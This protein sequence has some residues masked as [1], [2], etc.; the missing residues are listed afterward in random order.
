M[1][2]SCMISSGLHPPAPR[3]AMEYLR[4]WIRCLKIS[5][6]LRRKLEPRGLRVV[7]W[8]TEHGWIAKGLDIDYAVS[9]PSKVEATRRFENGLARTLILNQQAFGTIEHVLKPAP[10]DEWPEADVRTI[11]TVSFSKFTKT[12]PPQELHRQSQVA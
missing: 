12:I 10:K 5:Y 11:R 2:G 6:A 1:V 8:K 9:G 3:R 4:H 7:L